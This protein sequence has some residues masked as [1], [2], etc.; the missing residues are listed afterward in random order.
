MINLDHIE[1]L[2][3]R[4]AGLLAGALDYDAETISDLAVWFE[5]TGHV[6]QKEGDYEEGLVAQAAGS[7]LKTMHA[8]PEKAISLATAILAQSQQQSHPFAFLE[9]SRPT[10]LQILLLWEVYKMEDENLGFQHVIQKNGV[11]FETANQ[12]VH[13]N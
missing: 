6:L 10:L 5:I 8:E 12:A 11:P 1:V 13:M 4:L 9:I 2:A 7:L 3:K